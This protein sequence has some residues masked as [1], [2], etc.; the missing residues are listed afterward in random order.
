MAI[1]CDNIIPYLWNTNKLI[2]NTDYMEKFL[3]KKRWIMKENGYV[4]LK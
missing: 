4:H 1:G 2:Y 3:E